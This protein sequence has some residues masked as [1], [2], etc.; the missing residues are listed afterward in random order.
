M[1]DGLCGLGIAVRAFPDRSGLTDALRV[2]CP[3]DAVAFERLQAGLRAVVRPEALLLDMDGVLVDVSDSYREAICQTAA[4]FGVALSHADVERGKS[5]GGA[6]N[7]WE[8]TRR[9]LAER[10][11]ERPLAEVTERFESLYQGDSE[12]PGLWEKERLLPS[13]DTLR[14]LRGR[15]PLGIVTGRPRSDALCFLESRGIAAL[16]DTIVTM[17]DAPGKPSPEPVRRALDSLGVTR[18]WMLGDTPDDVA[19]ARAAGVV[20]LGILP[21]GAGETTREALARAGAAR[22]LDRFEQIEELLR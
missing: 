13:V 8:L 2:S 10:G 7:D 12:R 21:P 18:A 5:A 11:V 22:V 3:D 14:A 6:A 9:L 17:E 16:F 15:L 1:R 19:A 20:P 4:Q